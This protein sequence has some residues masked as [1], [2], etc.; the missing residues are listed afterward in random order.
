MKWNDR[1]FIFYLHLVH[2]QENL[3]NGT[4]GI[5][6]FIFKLRLLLEK[7]FIYQNEP[8]FYF[9]FN[10]QFNPRKSFV[11]WSEQYLSYFHDQLSRK[12]FCKLELTIYFCLFYVLFILFYFLQVKFENEVI[13]KYDFR[14]QI[15]W[16]QGNLSRQKLARQSF[17]GAF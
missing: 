3:Y 7:L 4:N 6:F 9:Y 1:C 10:V 15:L 11:C 13:C 12:I 17:I 5:L 14:L 2:F 16:H 8:Y